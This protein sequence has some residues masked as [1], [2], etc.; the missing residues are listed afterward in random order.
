MDISEN[1]ITRLENLENLTNL[2]ELYIWGNPIKEI[3]DST[4]ESLTKNL[5]IK[6]GLDESEYMSVTRFVDKYELKIIK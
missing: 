6:L 4:Y 1:K 5:N 3:T 2:K